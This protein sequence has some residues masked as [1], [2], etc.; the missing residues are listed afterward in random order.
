M[1]NISKKKVKKEILEDIGRRLI[2]HIAN[3]KTALGTELFLSGLFT[4]KER[5]MIAKRFTIILL[6][7]KKYAFS[8]IERALKVSPDTIARL[9][10]KRRRGDYDEL[11]AQFFKK[12][13]D[14]KVSKQNKDFLDVVEKILQAGLPPMYGGDRYR[15]FPKNPK[16]VNFSIKT[17]IKVFK[18]K[19]K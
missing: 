15:A 2:K 14:A 5:I 12:K 7:E 19:K 9:Q 16:K 1:V 3:L 8:V 17:G 11:I 4:K 13:R 10:Q 6:L 18:K